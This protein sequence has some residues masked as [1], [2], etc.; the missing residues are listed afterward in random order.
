[1]MIL[2]KIDYAVP[3]FS[4]YGVYHHFN[5]ISVISWQLVLLVEE[6]GV[7]R[8]NHRHVA[9]HWQTLSHNV[10]RY[11]SPCTGFELTTLMVIGT[12]C[13][14][15]CKSNY[16]TMT[17]TAALHLS[18]K[19]RCTL[20]EQCLFYFIKVD[21]IITSLKTGSRH[22]DKIAEKFLTHSFVM[23]MQDEIIKLMFTSQVDYIYLVWLLKW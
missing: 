12:D 14:G 6:T 9:S 23:R 4:S 19:G 5:N 20:H 17:T 8:E 18:K 22:G 13:T 1:M 21:I 16:D 11:I 2:N 7:P 10:S 15:S 3:F